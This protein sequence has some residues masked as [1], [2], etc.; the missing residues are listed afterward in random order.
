MFRRARFSVKPNVR[1][2]AAGRSSSSSSVT[3]EDPEAQPGSGA[4]AGSS[5]APGDLQQGQGAGAGRNENSSDANGDGDGS[6]H[7]ETVLQRRKRISTMP[8]LAK[9]RVAPPSTQRAVSLVSK[10]PQKP[11][12]Q[13][14]TSGSTALQKESPE[15]VNVENS[16]KSPILPEKKTPVPQVPQFSPF[17]KC[18]NKEPNACAMAPKSDEALQKNTSSPLKERP[19]QERLIQE[20]MPPSKSAPAKEKRVSSE[21]EK[22]LKTQKLRNLLKEELKKEK[23]KCKY[24]IIEKCIPEDRSKMLM[25]DFIYYLPENN[26]MKSSLVEEKKTEKT[27]T[28][29]QA[30]EPEQKTVADHEDENEEAEE[31]EGEEEDSPL[32]VPRVKVAEDGS[33]ILDEESLTVEVLRTKG[34]C[35]VEQNDP[36]FER[37]STT[38]Y[39]SFRKSYYTKPWSEKETDMFFLAISMVGTDFSMIS[40]L[41]PHR[42]RTEIKNKF[43]R[44]EKTNGWRIDKAFKE[45]KPFDFDFFAKLLEKVLE[46]ERKKKEK[47]AKCQSSKEKIPKEKKPLKCQKKQKD[48]N[49]QSHHGQDDHQNGKM[50]DAE[51]EVDS[52]TAEKENEASLSVLEQ[53]EGQTAAESGVAKKKRKRKKKDSEQEA[54]N[55]PEEKTISAEMPEGKRSRKRRKNASSSVETN[56]IVTEDLEIPDEK[57]P[58]PVEEEPQRIIQLNEE[59]KGDAT[60]TLLSIQPDASIETESGELEFLVARF[61]HHVGQPSKS[62][63]STTKIGFEETVATKNDVAELNKL[64]ENCSIPAPSHD[65]DKTAKTEGATSKKPRVK[66]QLQRLKSDFTRASEKE[67]PQ[68][69]DTLEVKT[70]LSESLGGTEKGTVENQVTKASRPA[71]EEMTERTNSDMERESQKSLLQESS[72]PTILK[73]APLAR[74]RMQRPKPNLQKV[75]RRQGATRNTESAGEKLTEAVT[76]TEKMQMHHEC[77]HDELLIKDIA[78]ST[79]YEVDMPHSEIL[80]NKDDSSSKKAHTNHPPAQ[81][82][83]DCENCELKKTP[84]SNI[85]V[86]DVSNPAAGDSSLQEEHKEIA[87]EIEHS[88]KSYPLNQKENLGKV[89]ET[90]IVENKHETEKSSIQLTSEGS[91]YSDLNEAAKCEIPPSSHLLKQHS[92]HTQEAVSM[93]KILQSPENLLDSG[94]PNKIS[95]SSDI[96]EE[97][98]FGTQSSQ[99]KSNRIAIRPSLLLRGRFQRPKPN[100]GRAIGRKETQSAV[101]N[102]ATVAIAGTEKSEIQTSARTSSTIPPLLCDDKVLPAEALENRLVDSEK[103]IQEDTQIPSTSQIISDQCAREKP[104]FQEDKSC[105]IMPTPLVRGRFQRARPNLGRKRGKKEEPVSENDSVSVSRELGKSETEVIS[106]GDLTTPSVDEGSD[107]ISLDHLEKKDNSESSEA[108]SPET[109]NEQKKPSSFKMLQDCELLKDQEET[110]VCEDIEGKYL[111]IPGSDISSPQEINKTRNIKLPQLMQGFLQKPKPNLSRAAKK[112]T[113]SEGETFSGENNTEDKNE[114]DS[115]VDVSLCGSK[116]GEIPI[117]MHDIGKLEEA[118]STS[119]SVKEKK[120]TETTEAVSSKRRR[121][122]GKCESS[123]QLSESES[124]TGKDISKP[125]SA[126]EKAT[127]TLKRKQPERSL[128]QRKNTCGSKATPSTSECETDNGEKGRRLRKVK[129]NVSRGKSLKSALGKK[130]RKEFGSSKV[131]LV[132]LRAS[133]R[134]EEEDEDADDFEPDY[135]VEC[136]SPEEVNKAPVF[137]PKGL[138]SP[139]PVPVQIEETMEELE[140]YENVTESCFAT[141]EYLCPVLNVP[142]EPVIQEDK[143]LPSSVVVI[144]QKEPENKTG[145]NDGSTEAAMTLLAMRDP[146][147]QLNTTK[148]TQEFP[149][150]DEL[151][152]ADNSSKEPNEEQSII[153]SDLPPSALSTHELVSSHNTNKAEPKDP[154]TSGSEECSQEA[155]RFWSDLSSST[156]NKT[157]KLTRRRFPKPNLSKSLR[158]KRNALKKSLNP[159]LD[160]THSNEIQNEEQVSKNVTEE[161]KVELEQNLHLDELPKS[162]SVDE[163]DLQ[164]ESA[165]QVMQENNT[166]R[167]D[168]VKETRE[169]RSELTPKPSPKAESCPPQLP[170]EPNTDINV[171]FPENISGPPKCQLSKVDVAQTEASKHLSLSATAEI[172]AVNRSI[173]EHPE[174]E[175]EQTFILTLV[176]ISAN[177]EG[178][179]DGST[180]LQHASEELPLT[181]VLFSPDNTESVELTRENSIRSTTVEENAASVDNPTEPE[182]LQTAPT[183][184]FTD[185]IS[186]SWESQKRDAVALEGSDSCPKKKKYSSSAEES[187]KSSNKETSLKLRCIPR[188]AAEKSS[189]KLS[190]S[191]KKNSSFSNLVHETSELQVN[192][193]QLQSPQNLETVPFDQAASSDV[194][195]PRILHGGKAKT[196]EQ[197][198]FVNIWKSKQSEQVGSAVVLPKMPLSRPSKKSLGFLPLICKKDNIDEEE[199]TKGNKQ[200]HQ[201]PL[202][203]MPKGTALSPRDK[204]ESHMNSS[205][206][207]TSSSSAKYENESSSTVQFHSELSKNEGSSKEQEKDEEPTKISEYF[208]SDIFMEV[209]DSE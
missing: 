120:C 207:T 165:S 37:G 2:A 43:K 186:T 204:K 28:V 27:S 52:G 173:I 41:F 200:S 72:E 94:G 171:Q 13:P 184:H 57:T 106:K 14:P 109:S 25:R 53:A 115:E 9:P 35:V 20:E 192:C 185:P 30:N 76:E 142:A 79:T 51:M 100:I 164:P 42:A 18:V 81:E 70:S 118:V 83:L 90:K 143:E 176:E 157:S 148:E 179:S 68:I 166:E 188:K 21:Q 93:H 66:G 136:F 5:A 174:A 1:P 124:Q 89:A 36:I 145:I 141:T 7:S 19:T 16:S 190:V 95:L 102:E 67:E 98:S 209:D 38:T 146:V 160:V 144:S 71:T 55:V 162:I 80:E 39:S 108:K 193:E 48:V 206:P 49:G 99:E 135:E 199:T 74:G 167:Q 125:L 172:T 96:Q 103:L 91:K 77:S 196:S 121:P 54:D 177:S 130:S 4:P 127:E 168:L 180:S 78:E 182:E 147:F 189:E 119:E 92:A 152:I 85:S 101:K 117:L 194:Q 154:S 114:K 126:R 6:K 134:E 112:E 44:E 150:Q 3:R 64:D 110:Y 122:S 128:K 15:K 29:T 163:H 170:S 183:K 34:Q 187:L 111:D 65:D 191:K 131:N 50:S 107:Q 61:E 139:N 133:S 45:K 58:D 82:P 33:I 22:I 208:F 198:S 201:K 149:H 97:T 17:K 87:A 86:E 137:V 11:V 69:S 132:T 140:I 88:L 46:N 205:L 113:F 56:G 153:C 151:N 60:L 62:S 24:P 23:R 73:P 8:N 75:T 129:P 178:C 40:Q 158:L 63:P 104:T 10:R 123:E 195:E 31:E 203:L 59:A 116:S 105:T 197:R 12:P 47:D 181:P 159:S 175:D 84:L 161:Q 26:P 32:L 155:T 156:E 138:R 202:T 169:G